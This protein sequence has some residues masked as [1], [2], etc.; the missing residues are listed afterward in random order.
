MYK[1]ILGPSSGPKVYGHYKAPEG[2]Q[3][4]SL[5]AL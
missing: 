1:F 5:K 2:T 4:E 3:V